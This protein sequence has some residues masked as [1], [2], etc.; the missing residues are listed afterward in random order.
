LPSTQSSNTASEPKG[1]NGGRAVRYL[2][3]VLIVLSVPISL[4][5][6]RA[7]HSEARVDPLHSGP[8]PGFALQSLDGQTVSLADYRGRPLVVNFWGAWCEQCTLEL[9]LLAE[10]RRRFPAVPIVG[11]LY[12]EDP[13]VGRA[14]AQ[15]GDATWPTLVDPGEKVA[16]AY[17]VAGAP[18]T[19][20]IRPDGTIAGDLLGPVST[21]ILQKQFEKIAGPS[22]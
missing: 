4:V 7:V 12:R 18:A 3:L 15:H 1:R 13:E 2:A 6:R 16:E 14:A 20:F 9:P 8:A 10:M 11:V 5:V 19:F 17:G 21:G 22:N